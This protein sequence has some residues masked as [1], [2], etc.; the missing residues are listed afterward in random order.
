VNGARIERI[1][2]DPWLAAAF[3]ERARSFAADGFSTSL[4]GES[5]QVLLQC[6]VVAACDAVLAVEGGPSKGRTAVIACA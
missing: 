2:P 1:E 6:A 3:L 5:R 4:K